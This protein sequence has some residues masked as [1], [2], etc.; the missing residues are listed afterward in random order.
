MRMA[1]MDYDIVVDLFDYTWELF[2]K[3]RLAVESQ[4]RD[5]SVL[6]ESFNDETHS[7][8]IIYHFKASVLFDY[9]TRA[10]FLQLMTSAFMALRPDNYEPFLEMPLSEYR[11]M[12]IDPANQ[13]IDQ[14]GLQSLV[15]GVISPAG[16]ALEVSYLDR[17]E[18]D[19]VTP[20][21]FVDNPVGWPTIRLLYRP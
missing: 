4:S 2:E 6:M 18:G 16:I 7:N 13:E 17:S 8:S 20:H 14:I 19:Q 5:D 21:Q 15:D 9:L 10:E 1:G 11:A 12:R 3:I